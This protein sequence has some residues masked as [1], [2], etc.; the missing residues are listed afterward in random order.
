M[1]NKTYTDLEKG[2]CE[3]Y[4]TL[5]DNLP[6]GVY[7]NT[8]GPQG[9]FLEANPAIIAMFEADSK[10]EFMKH[11]VSD[12]Y[13]DPTKRKLFVEKISIYGFVKNE[14]LELITLKGKKI[15]CSI[16]ATKNAYQDGSVYFDGIIEDIT[17]HKKMEEALKNVN[18]GLEAKV[19]ERTKDLEKFKLA[20]DNS[21]EHIVITDPEGI[22][23][24]GNR[25]VERITGYEIKDI[26]G[27]KV[28]A[29]WKKPMT[30]EYY[31]D[32]WN[33][34]KTKKKP[35]IGEI[36]NKRKNGEV[37]TALMSAFPILDKNGNILFFVGI[38]HDITREKEI[39][40]EKTEFVSL[41]S[42]QLRTPL[43]AVNWYCEMLISGGEGKLNRK[44]KEYLD[45]IYS[46]SKRMVGLVNALLNVSRME[47]G[48]FVVTPEPTDILALAKTA[49]GE[50]LLLVSR[51]KIILNQKYANNLPLAYVDPK[52]LYIVFQNIL[53]N[54]VNYTPDYG[55]IDFDLHLVKRGQLIG[56]Q[57]MDED[58]FAIVISDTGYG[59]PKAQQNRIFTKLFRGD[60]ILKEGTEKTGFGT[61]LGLYITETIV[62]HSG[63]TIWFESEENKGTT[64]YITLPIDG[65]KKTNL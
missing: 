34:I 7:R 2:N 13:Q 40:K 64:F 20:V 10:E 1:I 49:V 9:H 22:V 46:G 45:A 37:Y 6:V 17:E 48:T 4:Q 36:Q 8:P 26:L 59:I 25:A 51:K 32:F 60:N 50:L 35:Y 5:I 44:Q 33:T 18:R 19:E 39:D 15:L 38:E 30:L 54:A 41:T 56:A 65:P 62:K 16:T 28:G 12:L 61:G 63:G 47:L 3:K 29:L 58:S 52:L 24:Y 21:T 23:T 31:Q 14:E 43:T 42:H 53:S 11:N 57:K 27:K 55:T